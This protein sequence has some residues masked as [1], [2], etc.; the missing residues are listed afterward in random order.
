MDNKVNIRWVEETDSTQEE[1]RRGLSGYDNLSVTAALSQTAGR[2]QRG[3]KWVSEKGKNLTFSILLKFGEHGFPPLPVSR[4]F[5]ISKAATLGVISYLEKRGVEAQVKWP[6]DIYIRNKKICGM[7]V[8]SI[9]DGG[10]V[11]ASIVGIGLNVNQT[12]FDPS[13]TNPTSL[14]IVTG[15]EYDLRLELEK[16]TTILASSFSRVLMNN[17][18]G[19]DKEYEIRLYRKGESHEYVSCLDGKVFEGVIVGVSPEGKLRVHDKKGELKEFAF[20]EINY[21]I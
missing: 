14:A 9:L 20:K 13:L 2:G 16:F 8:E 17:D 12:V 7:L 4:Q 18:S 1:L 19:I 3:N 6:N 15:G 10:K 21:I 11:A 5:D